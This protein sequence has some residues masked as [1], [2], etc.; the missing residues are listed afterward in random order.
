MSAP[1]T[2]EELE[3]I[4]GSPA[5][6]I[7]H[8]GLFETKIGEYAVF[9]TKGLGRY[10]VHNDQGSQIGSGETPAAA[11]LSATMFSGVPVSLNDEDEEE[12]VQS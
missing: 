6:K 8:H 2:A 7:K 9:I 1:L 12:E 4:S 5:W 11:M 3:N 10:L